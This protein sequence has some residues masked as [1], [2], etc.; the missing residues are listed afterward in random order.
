MR[1]GFGLLSA[2]PS[3]VESARENP[4]KRPL[5]ISGRPLLFA[6]KFVLNEGFP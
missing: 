6:W 3:P 1:R 5:T 4:N 2:P